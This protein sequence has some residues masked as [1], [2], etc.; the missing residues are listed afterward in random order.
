MSQNSLTQEMDHSILPPTTHTSHPCLPLSF[1]IKHNNKLEGQVLAQQLKWHLGYLHSILQ[2]LILSLGPAPYPSFCSCAHW[3]QQVMAH[4]LEF[5]PFHGR[6]ELRSQLLA[7]AWASSGCCRLL[8]S[9]PRDKKSLSTS[10]FAI[11]NFK[12]INKTWNLAS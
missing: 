5:L 2:C 7:P 9:D 8:G 3:R 12:I 10:F 6:P 4:I 1:P 11:Q